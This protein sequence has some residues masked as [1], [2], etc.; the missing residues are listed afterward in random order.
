MKFAAKQLLKD[1]IG[2]PANVLKLF[3]AFNFPAPKIETIQK[4][5]TRDSISAEWLPQLLALLELNSGAP[6]SL[7]AYIYD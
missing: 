1:E 4:W 3:Q 2:A 5:Y 7:S 6:V